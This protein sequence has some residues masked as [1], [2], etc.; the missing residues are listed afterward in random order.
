MASCFSCCILSFLTI[1]VA[2]AIQP[3]QQLTASSVET[4][5][6]KLV[7]LGL[8]AQLLVGGVIMLTAC[9]YHSDIYFTLIDR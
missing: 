8:I 5:A 4:V 6:H 1:S 2:R 9:R 7:K 3:V